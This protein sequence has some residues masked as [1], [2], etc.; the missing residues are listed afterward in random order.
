MPF[1]L[2]IDGLESR[3]PDSRD[4]T[5]FGF[6][7][8]SFSNNALDSSYL[9]A[10]VVTDLFRDAGLPAARTAFMRVF[11]DRGAGPSISGSTR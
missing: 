11:L 10:K 6:T 7:N 5:F 1:R 9:R 2:N 3:F 8:L 4:Q